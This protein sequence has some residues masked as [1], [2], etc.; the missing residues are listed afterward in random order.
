MSAYVSIKEIHAIEM[1][2][3]DAQRLGYVENRS[4]TD[5][6][7]FKITYADGGIRWSNRGAF[8]KKYKLK[9]N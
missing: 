3:F 1:S 4:A 6:P 8:L 7:G 5:T 2:R 9:G